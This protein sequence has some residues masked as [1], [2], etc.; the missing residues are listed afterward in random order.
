M[1]VN[2]PTTKQIHGLPNHQWKG[3]H[4]STTQNTRCDRGLI[5]TFLLIAKTCERKFDLIQ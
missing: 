4:G 3:N 2:I 5:A 1:R